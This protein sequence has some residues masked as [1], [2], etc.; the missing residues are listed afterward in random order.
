M[1]RFPMINKEIEILGL[2]KTCRILVA[3]FSDYK[4]GDLAVALFVLKP[5]I[6]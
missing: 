5:C 2:Q 4:K 3:L 1:E 6:Y